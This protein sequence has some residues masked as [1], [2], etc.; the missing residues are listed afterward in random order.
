MRLIIVFFTALIL[1]KCGNKPVDR[2]AFKSEMED[3]EVMRVTQGQI[4]GY[5][6]K[7]GKMVLD[8]LQKSNIPFGDTQFSSI[9]FK[10]W[11]EKEMN[12]KINQLI[13][14][15]IDTNSK[16]YIV[17]QAYQYNMSNNIANEDNLQKI[18]EDKLIITRPIIENIGNKPTLKG[19]IVVEMPKK[20]L[21]KKMTIKDLKE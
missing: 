19:L 9:P 3:R 20:E 7:K 5:A 1:Y 11:L 14:Q 21:I 6:F 2:N 15:Q 16:L 17:Y 13:K 10:L 8:S 18:G 4:N 12:F